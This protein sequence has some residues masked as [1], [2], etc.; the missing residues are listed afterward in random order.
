MQAYDSVVVRSDVEIGATEQ[1]FN[2]LTGRDIQ[3]AYGVEPQ[4]IL[5]LPVLEGLDGVRRMS[6][7][8][9]NYIGV[10]EP[11]KEIYGKVM[12]SRPRSSG[13][14]AVRD[15]RGRRNARDIA[16]FGTSTKPMIWKKKLAHRIV[17]QYHGPGARTRRPQFEKQFSRRSSE[18]CPPSR[19]TGRFP[20]RDLMMRLPQSTPARRG[21]LFKQ[22]RYSSTDNGLRTSGSRSPRGKARGPAVF[23]VGRKV[24]SWCRQGALQELQLAERR[25]ESA[26]LRQFNP[27]GES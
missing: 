24:T 13:T 22:G 6:K 5:T 16:R 8:L 21:L 14:S 10:T 4:V 11:P 23:K 9:G 1:K 25:V 3:I 19:R 17:A 12:T 20:G 2:L 15:R 18:R 7:S 27:V 26:S